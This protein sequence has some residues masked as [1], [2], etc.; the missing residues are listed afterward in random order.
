MKQ[1]ARRVCWISAA[2]PVSSAAALRPLAREVYLSD[3]N[4][5][6]VACAQVTA[7]FNDIPPAQVHA[8]DVYSGLPAEF[9]LIVSNPPFHEGFETSSA[10]IQRIIDGAPDHLRQGGQLILVANAFLPYEALMQARLADL[11]VL[12]QTNR[13][14]VLAARKA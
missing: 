1:P 12:A 9:D 13:F 11:R 6:A 7:E 8:A 3:V 10:V 4:L 2:V 5:L 14:K